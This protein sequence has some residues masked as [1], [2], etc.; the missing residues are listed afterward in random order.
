MSEFDDCMPAVAVTVFYTHW[1]THFLPQSIALLSLAARSCMS[2]FL[3]PS[4]PYASLSALEEPAELHCKMPTLSSYT[5]LPV[6]LSA[7]H[8]GRA[9]MCHLMD[10]GLFGT[11]GRSSSGRDWGERH[12]EANG[13]GLT[14][15]T[16][17]EPGS[18]RD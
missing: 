11:T 1:C 14:R 15:Q 12:T 10:A 2:A 9:L 8:A 3:T 7:Q 16:H 4:P 5:M 18:T 13:A 17:S 6:P